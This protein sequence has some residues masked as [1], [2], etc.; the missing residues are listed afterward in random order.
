MREICYKEDIKTK[1][2]SSSIKSELHQ[3]QI[4]FEKTEEF[5]ELAK[6]RYMIEAKNSEIKNCHGFA[7]SK[8]NGLFGMNIQVSTTLFVVNLKRIMT[9]MDK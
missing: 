1:T 7:T 3:G 2:Y 6:N 4:D 5:K 9:L 8:S